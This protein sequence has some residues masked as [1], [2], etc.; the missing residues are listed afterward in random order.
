MIK[1]RKALVGAV[2][3]CNF[4]TVVGWTA[5]LFGPMPAAAMGASLALLGAAQGAAWAPSAF[6]LWEA[7]PAA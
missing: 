1:P 2:W 6:S 5:G 7:A 4:V 3:L